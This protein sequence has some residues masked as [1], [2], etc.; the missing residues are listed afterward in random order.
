MLEKDPRLGYGRGLKVKIAALS[1]R[2]HRHLYPSYKSNR[3]LIVARI[4]E[5]VTRDNNCAPDRARRRPVA[6]PGLHATF[7]PPADR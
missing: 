2:G 5:V 7:K 3:R 4:I 1:E 6:P